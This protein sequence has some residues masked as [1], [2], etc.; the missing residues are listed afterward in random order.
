VGAVACDAAGGTSADAA[1]WRVVL[2]SG[3]QLTAVALHPGALGPGERAIVQV[4]EPHK[5]FY[6]MATIDLK[7][8]RLN[9]I[10][11]DYDGDIWYPGWTP[12]GKIIATGIEYSFSLWQMRR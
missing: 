6:R 4:N 1:E 5:W 10:P 11:V 8:G 3:T 7:T 2:S 9:L 12:D